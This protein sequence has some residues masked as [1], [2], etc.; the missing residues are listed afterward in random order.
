MTPTEVRTLAD[1]IAKD[2]RFGQVARN[3]TAA[4]ANAY[5]ELLALNDRVRLARQTERVLGDTLK[6]CAPATSAPA[7]GAPKTGTQEAA[8]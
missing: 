1:R 6:T 2:P 4:I 8:P 7:T 5:V 3:V